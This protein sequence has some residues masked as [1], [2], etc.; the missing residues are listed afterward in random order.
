MVYALSDLIELKEKEVLIPE[1]VKVTVNGK[2]VE[3]KGDKGI[4]KEDFSHAPVDLRLQPNL[5][6]VQAA[7]PRKR[8]RALVRTIASL[9][10]NMIIG[11]TKGFIYKLKIVY[12]HFPTS[13]RVDNSRRQIIIENFLGEKEPR[14][15]R[16]VGDV[17]V[18]ISEEDV[19]VRGTRLQDVSQTAANIEQVTKIKNKD[20]RVFLDGIYI[21]DKKG[22]MA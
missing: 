12:A 18:Q 21:Y 4:L 5:L 7:W 6:V 17:D 13:V 20:L 11:V 10:N 3:V 15:A 9:I 16:M 2:V 8:E 14:I 19:I 1:D 22:E